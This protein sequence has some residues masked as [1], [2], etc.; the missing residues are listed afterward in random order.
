MP[1]AALLPVQVE[2][3]TGALSERHHPW[4]ALHVQARHEKTVALHLRDRGYRDFLPVY[5]CTHRW[6]DRV[7]KI[8]LP[9]FPGYLFCRLDAGHRVP[10]VTIP[11]VINIVGI[12]KR[13][14][15]VD[16]DEIAALQTVMRS[17]LLL[18]PWP[19]LK[20][21]Q[22]VRIQD[23]PLRNV[24]GMLSEVSDRGQF[25]VSVTLL[26]RSVAVTIDRSWIRP[27]SS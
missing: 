2:P 3:P 11:G 16:E 12:A 8:E 7:Q 17:G 13:P 25:V 21:G 24:E 14:H 23:G 19:F 18:E 27:I 9:L 10:V 22:R 4:Y 6:S 15:P 26:Q 5:T 1:A 20:A